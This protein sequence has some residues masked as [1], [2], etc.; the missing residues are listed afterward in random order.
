MCAS[1]NDLMQNQVLL[2]KKLYLVASFALTLSSCKSFHRENQTR[3]SRRRVCHITALSGEC[4]LCRPLQMS[5]TLFHCSQK[6]ATWLYMLLF[7]RLSTNLLSAI[8]YQ[9]KSSVDCDRSCVARFV[10]SHHLVLRL[11]VDAHHSLVAVGDSLTVRVFMEK[12][13]HI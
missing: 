11:G 10:R 1:N 5:I 12:G 7:L 4:G 13:L 6:S 9:I 3:V 2:A 8:A